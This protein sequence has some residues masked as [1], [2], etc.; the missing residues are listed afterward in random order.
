MIPMTILSGSDILAYIQK[1]ELKI[2]PFASESLTSAGYDLR[3]GVDVKIMPRRHALVHTMEFVKLGPSI[4][5][6]LSIRSS[7]TREGLL[8]SFA[9]VDPGFRG[10]L[11]LMLANLGSA[12]VGIA[13]GERVAQIVFVMLNK[14][15]ENPY[16]GR[17]QDSVGTV[18]SK[19]NF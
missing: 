12:P 5:G 19:R 13:K 8:G 10:Q 7:F 17:Y 4:C 14:A 1:G 16:S 15:S 3:S 6:Q 9:L 11:T 18:G 2:T